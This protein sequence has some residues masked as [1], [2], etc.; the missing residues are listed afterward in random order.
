VTDDPR[1]AD[2]GFARA[3]VDRAARTGDPEVGYGAG[4]SP[5]QIVGTLETLPGKNPERAVLATRPSD[6]AMDVL[7]TTLGGTQQDT[8]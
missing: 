6:E 3:D 1:T 8:G 7:A 4:S 2:L 5:A